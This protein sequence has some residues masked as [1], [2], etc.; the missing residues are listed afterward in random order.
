VV[1]T[2]P[3]AVPRLLLEAGDCIYCSFLL[4]I[5]FLWLNLIRFKELKQVD[6]GLNLFV[7]PSFQFYKVACF[8][9]LT[10]LPHLCVFK[11]VRFHPSSRR[12]S[13]CFQ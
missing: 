2:G 5:L 6:I 4:C 8:I 11:Y 10:I 7:L 13:L 9:N 1:L 3:A 12:H